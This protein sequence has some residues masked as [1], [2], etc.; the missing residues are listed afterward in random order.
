MSTMQPKA[1]TE[2]PPTTGISLEQFLTDPSVPEHSEWVRG[3]VIEM[4]PAGEA[5]TEQCGF[6]IETLRIYVRTRKLGRVLQEPYQIAL[7]PTQ[8]SRAPDAMVVLNE[9]LD[10]IRRTRLDGP[11]D[12]VVEVISP[13]SRARDRGEKFYEYEQAGVPEYWLIDPDRRVAEFYRL[14]ER[15]Y[16]EMASPDSDGRYECSSV[17]GLWILV[18]W[19]WDRPSP[20][21]VQRA[22]G[23]IP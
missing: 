9:H 5:H 6:L 19:L 12:L 4:P 18:D 3:A 1:G 15:G 10:R 7:E 13:E 11:A 16:Y 17:P 21:E 23:L 8:S 20:L 22:W 2:S 14:G